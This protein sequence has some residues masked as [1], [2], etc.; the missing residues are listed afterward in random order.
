MN[1]LKASRLTVRPL[2]PG[3]QEK[4]AWDR[5]VTAQPAGSFFHLAGWKE[6]IEASFGH[7]CPYLLAEREGQITGVLPLT[8]VKSRLFGQSLVSNAFCVYG[9]P[10]AG[11]PESLAALDRTACG[12]AEE[13]GVESLEYRLRRRFD[14]S[15]PCDGE[16]YATFRKRLDPDPE[17]N[18]AKIRRKQRAMVR[19]ALKLGLAS[20]LDQGPERLYRLY[21]ESLR[22]L[23]TPVFA[24]AYLDN[25][26]R[27]FRHQ[28]EV[29]V[30]SHEG[31]PV[32][33]VISFFFRDEVLPYYGGGSPE[34]R[35]L[36]AHDFMYWEVLR[37]A[38][39]AGVG[40][41]D[42]GRSK[43]GTGAYDFKRHWGFEPE[44]LYYEHRLFGR[45]EIPQRNPLNPK[46]A[47]AIALW[48]KLPLPLAK[49]PG[50]APGPGSGLRGGGVM[51]A[52][53]ADMLEKQELRSAQRAWLMA[54]LA[55]AL[56]T[57]LL[58]VLRF[59][60]PAAMVRV[61]LASET[62]GYGFLI[63]PIVLFLIWQRRAGLRRLTPRPCFW[64]LPWIVAGLLVQL[65]GQVSS[66]MLLQELAFVAL[67]QGLFVL[68]FGWSVTRA[69]LFPLFYLFFLVPAGAEVVPLLQRSTAEITV[70]L[71]RA[72][73]IPTF[74]DS[75]YIEIPS[76]SFVV[77]EVCSG[78][79]FLL[80]SLVLGVLASNLFFRSWWRR[81]VFMALCLVVPILANGLRAYGIIMLA[82]L[83]DYRLAV[84]V[85]HIVYGFIFLSLVLLILTGLGALFRDRWPQDLPVPPKD[86]GTPG[87]A[88]GFLAALL[89][90][91]LLLG[92]AQAWALQVLQPPA[93]P[94]RS[95]AEPPPAVGDWQLQ[96]AKAVAS[97]APAFPG[98]DR[99]G[100]STYRV[101]GAPPSEAVSFFFASYDYQRQDHEIIGSANS[102]IG[103]KRSNQI[104]R[105]VTVDITLSGERRTVKET[106]VQTPEGRHLVW[107][108][109]RIGGHWITAPIAGKAIEVWQSLTGG[110]RDASAYALA[111][112][113]R[114]D[115]LRSVRQ[116]ME[117]LAQ[118]L[119]ADGASRE[120][121]IGGI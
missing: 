52:T 2:G 28:A 40:V 54:G 33:A 25:L 17:A 30:V 43:A 94:A 7:R 24:R 34:A 80:T 39:E 75:V 106:L 36:A 42:F 92:G 53:P 64:A 62:F 23:G 61:W 22:N 73:G 8:H 85:D 44:P 37:R 65:V 14:E 21:A 118:A 32:S 31:R 6:V 63:L 93:V 15:R 47:L 68:I 19:K 103:K 59:E 115:D 11:D 67:W 119:E 29:L 120:T 110:R 114:D 116:R 83:S 79:R 35:A 4:A 121:L 72:S 111:T 16:T 58:F 102:F 38:A 1:A 56:A 90:G 112:P 41:F 109:Y 82:H 86:A 78:A 113:V 108:W 98:A 96:Q 20:E 88:A 74:L 55:F 105:F 13:M 51:V 91:G 95:A 117:A 104:L 49:P 45:Q 5:F 18:L 12:L 84:S 76:G 89:L 100:L 70:P 60:A 10:L 99:Q 46:Y 69:L 81:L 3:A 26:W 66:I 77:A 97:W 87:R 9:G 57:A 27:V 71:L 50:A 107:S 101:P 48:K